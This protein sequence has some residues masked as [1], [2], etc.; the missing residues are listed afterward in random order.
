MHDIKSLQKKLLVVKAF[1]PELTEAAYPVSQ[2]TFIDISKYGI[3]G[4]HCIKDYIKHNF[5]T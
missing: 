2:K 3:Y 4:L 5:K 1:E